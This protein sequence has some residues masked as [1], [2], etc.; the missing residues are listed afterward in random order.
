[1]SRFA[2]EYRASMPS[3]CSGPEGGFDCRAE[4]RVWSVWEGE[5]W[6]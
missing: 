1:M 2:K 5:S 4:R 3:S 6:A